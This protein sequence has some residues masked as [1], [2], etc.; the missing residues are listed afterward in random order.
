M[1]GSDAPVSN[2]GERDNL[3]VVVNRLPPVVNEQP[4]CESADVHLVQQCPGSCSARV[5][6][7]DYLDRFFGV[8]SVDET[9]EQRL[10]RF[11]VVGHKPAEHETTALVLLDGS[12]ATDIPLV[13]CGD[14]NLQPHFLERI[15][16]VPLPL[17]PEYVLVVRGQGVEVLVLVLE[18]EDCL[19]EKVF[20][21][22]D[23]AHHNG[24]SGGQVEAIICKEVLAALFRQYGKHVLLSR[25]VEHLVPEQYSDSVE[26]VPFENVEEATEG[27]LVVEH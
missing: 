15:S 17:E 14:P 5:K 26:H 12:E 13:P 7:A 8:T 24:S 6:R 25:G 23:G 20:G 21:H 18:N 1:R 4:W 2:A 27:H 10:C 22:A 11:R 9:V 16:E 19:L 3:G